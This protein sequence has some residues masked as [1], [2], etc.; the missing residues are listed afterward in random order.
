MAKITKKAE[1]LEHLNKLINKEA[2]MAQT[3]ISGKP[4][5]DTNITS[6]SDETESTDK[7]GVGPE[8]LNDKQSYKQKPSTD[9]SEP[10]ANAK[11]A[12]NI[13]K[14]ANEILNTI[15]AKLAENAQTNISGSPLAD[16][17]AASVDSSSER[18]DKNGVGP[19]KLN[20]KQKYSQKPSTDSSAPVKQAE[21]LAVK[22]ASYEMGRE[23]C[24]AIIKQAAEEQ[25]A[26]ELMKE[27]GRRDFDTLISQAAA[28]L[29]HQE[30]TA[31]LQKQAEEEYYYEMAKQAEVQGA[32]AFDELYKQAQYDS[33]VEQ[34]NQ[35]AIKVAAFEEYAQ[36]QL[37]KQ[38]A[39]AE[40][41]KLHKMANLVF[42]KLKNEL[43]KQPVEASR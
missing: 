20:S 17:N 19:E 6:V 21:E 42:S 4:G 38:A 34:N 36:D 2:E 31:A 35:L 8:N 12:S 39:Y 15:S 24:D 41:L 27:A 11:T 28:E 30:K 43:T 13:D 16:T 1:I 18:T 25:Q 22:L 14:L 23:Y 26:A 5:S 33:V 37:Q 29:E 40:E 32:Y 7:A 9:K 3:N 10:V